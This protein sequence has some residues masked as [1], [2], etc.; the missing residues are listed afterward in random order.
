[1]DPKMTHKTKLDKKDHCAS[2]KALKNCTVCEKK[3]TYPQRALSLDSIDLCLRTIL[4]RQAPISLVDPEKD[5]QI[6]LFSR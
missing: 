1:M 6:Q 4:V 5:T 2:F 3:E